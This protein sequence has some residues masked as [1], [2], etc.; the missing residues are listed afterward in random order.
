MKKLLIVLCLLPNLACAGIC[1]INWCDYVKTSYGGF[2]YGWRSMGFKNSYGE[3]MFPKNYQQYSLFAGTRLSD[4]WGL[5]LS[6]FSTSNEKRTAAIPNGETE[7]GI[8]NFTNGTNN[9]Y[10][11]QV[12]LYGGTLQLLASAPVTQRVRIYASGGLGIGRMQ[13]DIDLTSVNNAQPTNAQLN[14]NRVRESLVK[15]YPVVGAGIDWRV[16]KHL[17]LRADFAWED[18]QIFKFI[19]QTAASGPN[20]CVIKPSS[21]VLYYLG[22]YIPFQ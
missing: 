8:S 15:P 10:D 13:I 16:W 6:F 11:T 17:G 18:S 4:I 12:K 5:E 21:T 1:G 7:L 14:N 3:D 22:V 20:Q 2:R 9:T 19:Y